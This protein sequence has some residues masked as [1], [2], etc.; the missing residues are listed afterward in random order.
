M[1]STTV[2]MKAWLALSKL[3]GYIYISYNRSL[4]ISKILLPSGLDRHYYSFSRRGLGWVGIVWKLP[5]Q[6]FYV[7]KCCRSASTM[8][9]R[10]AKTPCFCCNLSH[11]CFIMRES[12][13]KRRQMD[14]VHDIDFRGLKNRFGPIHCILHSPNGQGSHV[15]EG[16][17]VP[18]HC[19]CLRSLKPVP[20]MG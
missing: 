20:D 8:K 16:P 18:I 19:P 6:K 14:S 13:N 3:M 7:L 11:T 10:I 4:L 9:H 17:V 5:I 15:H 12:A 2:T 1:Y